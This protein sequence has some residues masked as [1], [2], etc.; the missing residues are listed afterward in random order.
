MGDFLRNLLLAASCLPLVVG[1]C[2]QECHTTPSFPSANPQLGRGE[3]SADSVAGSGQLQ[4][5][6]PN[7]ESTPVDEQHVCLRGTVL[8]SVSVAPIAVPSAQFCYTADAVSCSSATCYFA[9]PF[10]NAPLSNATPLYLAKRA[11]LI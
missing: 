9:R 2:W 1:C 3:A 6:F 7:E 4:A 5:T 10:R 8:G 11:I